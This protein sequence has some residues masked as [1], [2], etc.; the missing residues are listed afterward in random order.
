MNIVTVHITDKADFDQTVERH[1][2]YGEDTAMYR[3]V[4]IAARAWATERCEGKPY[5]YHIVCFTDSHDGI[6][7]GPT[8]EATAF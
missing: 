1:A 4:E 6:L 5:W 2:F 7:G 8:Y 3:L